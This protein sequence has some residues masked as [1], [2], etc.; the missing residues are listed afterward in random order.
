LIS[1]LREV[2]RWLGPQDRRR[3]LLL[4][5][6]STAAAVA[7]ALGAL[8]VFG[9]FRL[10]VEPDRVATTPIVM[11]A[12]RWFP[13]ADSRVVIAA[14]TAATAVFYL[15]RGLL[16]AASDWVRERAVQQSSA[17]TAERLVARYLHADYLFHVRR[18][19]ASLIEEASRSTDLAFQLVASSA[20]NLLTEALIAA[21]LVAVLVLN[22]PGVTLSTVTIVLAAAGAVVFATRRRWLRLG[23][24][25]KR[26]GAARLHVLQQSLTGIKD[27]II[28]GRQAFFESRFRE[29]RRALASMREQRLWLSSFTRIGVE[30]G[31]IVAMLMVLLVVVL[32]GGV[33]GDSISILALFGYTGIRLVPSAN[34]AILNAGYLREGSVFVRSVARELAGR[35][36][37]S[38]PTAPEPVLTFT[39]RIRLDDLSFS[40]E[41]GARPALAG[42]TVDIR[43][44]ESIGI[45]GPTGAGKSTLVDVLLGLLPPTSG[46]VLIDGVP[47]PGLERAWQRLIGYVPQDVYLLDDT[48]R[49]NIAFGIAD[50]L[51]D[52]GRLAQAITL[53][54]LDDV[55][56][57]L[58]ARLETIIGEDGIRLS[59]GQRQRVA[60][61][62]ALYHDPPVL[63]FDEATAAL[64][65]QTER[66][67]T[68][69]IASLHGAR[70]L[71]A[72]AHRLSTVKACDRLIYL[73]D[74]KVAGTGKY[75]ELI[76]DPM[77]RSLT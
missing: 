62:R 9:L 13:E 50:A 28:T 69:A 63:V 7:E 75:D 70:T 72:I 52:E 53:A 57:G 77:F 15:G 27:V 1:D 35:E 42:V 20:V 45:V 32:G 59:G 26:L 51:I 68:A 30:T 66:E 41:P 11:D 39:D 64:D 40:Y 18:Q 67:V 3:W 49:R 55:V 16:L 74:G 48:L 5:P 46:R 8:A 14:L 22:A 56:S 34:R 37:G 76:R 21:A 36:P 33:G 23:G 24:E 17:H 71:I 4:V 60:I 58:P 10:V 73:R 6:L 38:S 65:S 31:L 2:L 43:R 47:L 19:S 44:G 61:A 12:A 54:R 29:V 25:D